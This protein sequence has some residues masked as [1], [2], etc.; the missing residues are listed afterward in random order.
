MG[1]VR[2]GGGEEKCGGRC[3]YT[4][5]YR[6]SSQPHKFASLLSSQKIVEKSR[7]NF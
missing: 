4:V 7:F 2:S 5:T 3:E 1:S 6:L